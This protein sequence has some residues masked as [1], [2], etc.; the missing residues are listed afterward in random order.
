MKT[1]GIFLVLIL[2]ALRLAE[3]TAWPKYSCGTAGIVNGLTSQLCMLEVLLW[4][5][6]SSVQYHLAMRTGLISKGALGCHS[7]HRCRS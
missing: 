1:G 5:S 6:P 4:K 3:V 2:H 7:F